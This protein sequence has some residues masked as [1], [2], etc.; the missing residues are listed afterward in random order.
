MHQ[1]IE[2]VKMS[3]RTMCRW[4]AL[5]ALLWVL[6]VSL[7]L[8]DY[9]ATEYALSNGC[10]ELNPLVA[11]LF[12]IEAFNAVLTMKLFFLAILFV[13]LPYIKSWLLDLLAMT[14]LAYVAVATY[15][16]YGTYLIN[17]M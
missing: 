10:S 7:N 9:F 8:L 1:N 3:E 12:R 16:A 2:S 15:H 11:S 17:C 14:T 5:P 13:L 4:L 6:L